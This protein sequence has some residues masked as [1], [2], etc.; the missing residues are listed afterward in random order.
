MSIG[1]I[2]HNC[3]HIRS[4]N[5][6]SHKLKWF[7]CTPLPAALTAVI[8]PIII[9]TLLRRAILSIILIIIIIVTIIVTI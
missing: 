5:P 6:S 8:I 2:N 7:K 4:S 3:R 9:V 1:P